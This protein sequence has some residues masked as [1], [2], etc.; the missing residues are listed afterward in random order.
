[1]KS[2]EFITEDDN[3]SKGDFGAKSGPKPQMQNAKQ[4]SIAPE[5]E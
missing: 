3:V 4:I 1:M 2:N 5:F